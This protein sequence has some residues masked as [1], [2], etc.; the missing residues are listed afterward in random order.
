[1]FDIFQEVG[2]LIPFHSCQKYRND[3]E[4]L[5]VTNIVNE[6]SY[7]N[8]AARDIFLLCDNN[9]TVEDIFKIIKSEYKVDEDVL[10]HD[11][12]NFIRDLQWHKVIK[13]RTKN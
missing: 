5:I 6:I 4:F 9:N 12:V 3:N 8:N 10:K 11:I 1:M 13:M 7:L 2:Q